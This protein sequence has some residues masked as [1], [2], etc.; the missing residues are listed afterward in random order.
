M[1]EWPCISI[2]IAP[3]QVIISSGVFPSQCTDC[4]LVTS[5]MHPDQSTSHITSSWC[6]EA[7]ALL[8]TCKRLNCKS[9]NRKSIIRYFFPTVTFFIRKYSTATFPHPQFFLICN[10][11]TCNFK[12]LQLASKSNDKLKRKIIWKSVFCNFFSS[13]ISFICNFSSSVTFLHLQLFLI[14]N[15]LVLP[16]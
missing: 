14:S 3:I 16:I 10:F 15:F 9:L 2:I 4:W 13:A 7:T 1:N 6:P 11:L 12:Y 8:R 5:L